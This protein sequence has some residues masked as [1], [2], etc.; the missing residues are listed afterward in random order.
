MNKRNIIHYSKLIIKCLF[1]FIPIFIFLATFE[2]TKNFYTSTFLLIVA[3]I[4]F[5]FY[6]FHKEKRL[7]Y[8][9]LFICLE[10][11]FFGSLTLLLRDPIYVQM[12]DTFYDIALG[13]TILI[14]GIIRTPI[15]K[16]FFGHIF[17]LDIQTWVHLSYYWAT[18]L[19]TFGITNEYIR[20]NFSPD[21]WIRYKFVV[22]F[23][24]VTFGLTLLWKYRKSVKSVE[25]V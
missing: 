14:T 20:R 1:E 21:V 8:I 11:T 10:T 23:V 15:I 7:P 17:D 25:I 4:S 24:T 18:F 2:I 19:I 13:T 16:K 9:A 6:T 12:R 3:T 5:T 22:M